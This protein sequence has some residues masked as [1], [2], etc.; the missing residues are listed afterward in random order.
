MFLELNEWGNFNVIVLTKGLS[1]WYKS[2][3]VNHLLPGEIILYKGKVVTVQNKSSNEVNHSK[4][5]WASFWDISLQIEQVSVNSLTPRVEDGETGVEDMIQLQWEIIKYNTTTVVVYTHQNVTI[6]RSFPLYLLADPENVT[7]IE[8]WLCLCVCVCVY[9]DVH[10]G[11][12]L[13]NIKRRFNN[14]LIYV[15]TCMKQWQKTVLYEVQ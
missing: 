11:A 9:S 6:T 2:K 13:L 12:I 1:V 8:C 3:N 15:R 14:N 4:C 5:F 7:V 10:D